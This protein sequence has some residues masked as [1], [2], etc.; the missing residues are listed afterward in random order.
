MITYRPHFLYVRQY[1]VKFHLLVLRDYVREKSITGRSIG[2][3][4]RANLLMVR[5]LNGQQKNSSD[6][7]KISIY[8]L[9][10]NDPSFSNDKLYLI[11]KF[12]LFC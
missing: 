9:F 4:A 10:S 8:D 2:G 3:K 5:R 1:L 12:S 11:F 7:P 6:P